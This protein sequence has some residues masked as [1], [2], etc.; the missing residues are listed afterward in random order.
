MNLIELYRAR[1]A[2]GAA[3]LDREVPDWWRRINLDTLRMSACSSCVLGQLYGDY[4]IGLD[5]LH[6]PAQRE[7]PPADLL[8][9]KLGFNSWDF[10]EAVMDPET[11]C[12]VDFD[13]ETLAYQQGLA[14]FDEHRASVRWILLE[15]VWEDVIR[16]R[17]KEAEA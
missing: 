1:V 15:A 16:T 11:G 3:L 10:Y 9:V 8:E 2:Q 14:T 4:D 5:Q 12:E 13:T 7:T 6:I 17:R